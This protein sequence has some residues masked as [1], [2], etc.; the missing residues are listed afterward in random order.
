MFRSAFEGIEGKRK[1]LQA[2]LTDN[3][4]HLKNL[5]ELKGQKSHALE[6][7]ICSRPNELQKMKKENQFIKDELHQYKLSLETANLE[8]ESLR[9]G[10]S[11]LKDRNRRS[12]GDQDRINGRSPANSTPCPKGRSSINIETPRT[13]L[14][15]DQN[16]MLG[17]I[18]MQSMMIEHQL[19]LIE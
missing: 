17:M 1:A 2:L 3:Q 6:S 16:E 5:Q 8:L 19:E 4:N 18:L 12:L 11:M 13:N 7:Y 9:F 10:A 15:L 14:S